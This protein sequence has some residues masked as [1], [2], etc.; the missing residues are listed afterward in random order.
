MSI[1]DLLL[2]LVV[3]AVSFWAA[4]RIILRTGYSSKWLLA[5]FVSLVLTVIGYIKLYVDLHSLAFPIP[6]NFGITT[7]L[8]GLMGVGVVWTIDKFTI[9]ANWILFLIVAFAPWPA[10]L[11]GASLRRTSVLPPPPPPSSASQ[12]GRSGPTP[13]RG[14][15]G[16]PTPT[17]A[18]TPG[19]AASIANEDPDLGA[20]AA[21]A[22][23]TTSSGSV[24]IKHCV[25][26]GE[27]LPGSRA[28]FHDCGSKDR[29]ATNCAVCGAALP[30]EGA[31]CL[32]CASG[33]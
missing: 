25:W 1:F 11:T 32:A 29:P 14:P 8:T 15:G 16:S 30:S 13:F 10:G 17:A 12:P 23:P 22:A 2:I 3:L 5:P 4:A 6:F 27:S 33:Q 26:C 18:S 28:L 19:G 24:R 9:L 21:S 7:I 31:A 20:P